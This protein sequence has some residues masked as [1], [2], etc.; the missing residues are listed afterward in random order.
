[1][2]SFGAT[3][4]TPTFSTTCPRFGPK[5]MNTTHL[6]ASRMME[7]SISCGNRILRVFILLT[8]TPVLTH[9]FSSS[10]YLFCFILCCLNILLSFRYFTWKF[11]AICPFFWDKIIFE[12]MFLCFFHLYTISISSRK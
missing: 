6:I 5:T 8:A 7:T 4:I 2:L 11:L 9:H 1:M 3:L 10:R 12:I